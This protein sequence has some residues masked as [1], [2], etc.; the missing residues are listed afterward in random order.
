MS[1]ITCLVSQSLADTNSYGNWV[2]RE[3]LSAVL[4]K[5]CGVAFE[6]AAGIYNDFHFSIEPF[7]FNRKSIYAR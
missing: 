4:E 3:K 7:L 2:F 1:H 6:F 5:L